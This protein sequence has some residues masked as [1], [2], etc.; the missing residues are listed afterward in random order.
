MSLDNDV[1][2]NFN[3]GER[4]SFNMFS[5]LNTFGAIFLAVNS[6]IIKKVPKWNQ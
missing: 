2:E 4:S 3:V 5:G 1:N 6:Q